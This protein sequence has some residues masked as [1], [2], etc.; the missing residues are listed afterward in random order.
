MRILTTNHSHSFD[1][2]P[3]VFSST[4]PVFFVFLF[5][6]NIHHF[7]R[8]LFHNLGLNLF[9][10]C[11][12]IFYDLSVSFERMLGIS[13]CTKLGLLDTHLFYSFYTLLFIISLPYHSMNFQNFHFS[14]F[15]SLF[16]FHSTLE[17]KYLL[18]SSPSDIISHL[19]F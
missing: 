7:Y 16:S 4:R 17:Y 3:F 6:L 10:N 15:P 8:C 11:S 2:F 19:L 9:V 13:E 14:N 5:L 1:D 12:A 18:T